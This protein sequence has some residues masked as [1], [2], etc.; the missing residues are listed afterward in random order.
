VSQARKRWRGLGREALDFVESVLTTDLVRPA[1]KGYRRAEVIR[2]AMRFQQYTA[3]VMAKGLEDTAFYRFYRLI[4]CNEVGGDPRQASLSIA[5]FHGRNRE[6][7]RRWPLSMLATATHDTKRGEDA[8]ARIDVLSEIP[9]EWERGVRR[10]AAL[11]SRWKVDLD[12]RRAPRRNDEYLLY[13]TLIGAWPVE[14]EEPPFEPAALAEFTARIQAYVVKAARE[15]KLETSWA[16]PSKDYE[17]ALV[18]FVGRLL[19]PESGRVFVAEFLPLQRRIARI[20]MLN[21]L[22]QLT[23]K[24]TSPGVPDIYQG[25]EVWDLSLVDPDN[26]RRP[27]FETRRRSLA[28]LVSLS[29]LAGPERAAAVAELMRNW[30]DARIKMHVLASLLRLRRDREPLFRAS[31]YRAL[32]AEGAMADRVIAFAREQSG[33]CVVVATGRH[34]APSVSSADAGVAQYSW[35]DTSLRLPRLSEPVEDVLTGR[36]I[37]VSGGAVFARE[38][39]SILPVAVLV[40][41]RSTS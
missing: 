28:E 33:E 11:N 41:R 30:R 38:L 26:R 39:F 14:L 40:E 20:G 22:V 6:R 37:P 15:A 34:L 8:R 2:A 1:A 27:D 7:A 3:P 36:E 25:T 10:W 9:G 19:D 4:S 29:A 13:Q 23:L 21:S 31:R 24:L 17:D 12:D 18:Q 35:E 16:N 32:P 5:A